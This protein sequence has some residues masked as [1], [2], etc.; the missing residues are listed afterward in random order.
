M[1]FLS[2]IF[3][4]A[5]HR[6]ND[7]SDF[8]RKW[9]GNDVTITLFYFC[10]PFPLQT[11]LLPCRIQMS[12]ALSHRW[13]RTMKTSQQNKSPSQLLTSWQ[14][15]ITT[16]INEVLDLGE[17]IMW[18]METIIPNKWEQALICLWTDRLKLNFPYL[19]RHR[20]TWRWK[21]GPVLRVTSGSVLE[22]VFG[23]AQRTI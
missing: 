18:V 3:H 21:R 20:S 10:D 12:Q 11:L 15:K 7:I 6:K 1:H 13:Q 4:D 22:L 19:H 8:S 9:G 23:G 5:S 2:S 16:T 14:Y 17:D